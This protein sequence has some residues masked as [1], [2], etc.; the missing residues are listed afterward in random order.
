MG[1]ESNQDDMSPTGR[2][3]FTPR[4]RRQPMLLIHLDINKTIIQSDSIQMKSIEEGIREGIAE[5]FWGT[6][7][8]D[9][10]GKVVGW[11]WCKNRPSC[12]PPEITDCPPDDLYTYLSFCKKM[13]SE[14]DQQKL[15]IR[16]FRLVEDDEVKGEMIKV[17][18]LALKKLQLPAEVRFSP[19]AEAVGLKGSTIMMFPA[20][21]HLVA[22]LQRAKRKFAILFRSFGVDHENIKQEWNAFCEMRHPLYSR[23]LDGIGPMD[24]SVSRIPDRRIDAM[25]TLYRDAQGPLL[26]IDHLVE[27]QRAKDWDRWARERPTPQEDTRDG[28]D[29]ILRVLKDQQGARVPDGLDEVREWMMEHIES[30][31]TSAIKDDWAWW[32]WKN[33]DSS[34]GKLLTV[35]PDDEIK[36]VFFDDNVHH[37][38]PR[39][40]DCRYPDG[41]Q[42]APID[43]IDKLCCKVNSVEAIIDDEYFLRKLQICHGGNLLINS[44]LIDFQHQITEAEEQKAALQKDIKALQLQLKSITEENHRMK[45]LHRVDVENEVQLRDFLTQHNCPLDSFGIDGFRKVSDLYGELEQGRCCLE[46]DIDKKPVLIREMI[47]LKVLYKDLVLIESHEQYSDGRIM[48]RNFLPGVVKGLKESSFEA[49]DKFFEAGLEVN[50]S[51]CITEE[52]PPAFNP[53]AQT[54]RS[55]ATEA[56][57]IPCKVQ[58]FEA[59][60]TITDPKNF[61]SID[62]KEFQQQKDILAKIGLP[63]GKNFTTERKEM[64]GGKITHFWRW[65]KLAAW[66]ATALNPALKSD[67]TGVNVAEVVDKVFGNHPYREVYEN[68]LLQMFETFVAKKLCGG[69]SGSMVIRVQPFEKDGRPGE[70]CIVKLDRAD[71]IK[72]EH[73]NSIQ[74]FEALP[75]RAARI[76]GDAAYA[77]SEKDGTWFGAMR[78]EL[79]GA[80]WNVPELA[81]GSPNLLS[82]FKDLLLYESELMMLGALQNERNDARPFGSVNTVLAETFGPGGMV[83]S[84]RKGGKKGV[85]RSDQ[86]LPWGWYT[87]KGKDTD[88]NP[89]GKM[90]DTCTG[91]VMRQMYERHFHSEMPNLKELVVDQIKPRLERLAKK[92]MP[93]L[94]PLIGLAHG[95]LN[96]ANIMIDALDAVWLIDFATSVDLPLLTDL[97]KFEMACLFEYAILPITAEN[98]VDLSGPD[99]AHWERMGIGEWLGV[100]Q[101]VATSFLKL[102]LQ[103]VKRE[104]LASMEASQ[105]ESLVDEAIQQLPTH[106]Q[107]QARRAILSRLTASQPTRS[108]QAKTDCAFR[109]C[110]SIS[111]SMLSGDGLL[112]TLR[113]EAPRI[114]GAGTD[115]FTG[116]GSLRF[117]VDIAKSIRRFMLREIQMCFRDFKI[118]M[119]D[120]EPGELQVCDALSLQM[121][122]PFLRESYRIVGYRDIPP[123]KKLW[124]IYHCKVVAENVKR[125][126]EMLDSMD[127]LSPGSFEQLK[128]EDLTQ[129]SFNLNRIYKNLKDEITNVNF[130][131]SESVEVGTFTSEARKKEPFTEADS[132]WIHAHGELFGNEARHCR[133]VQCVHAE[134]DVYSNRPG[135][136]APIFQVVVKGQKAKLHFGED[137]PPQKWPLRL[138]KRKSRKESMLEESDTGRM[139]DPWEDLDRELTGDVSPGATPIDPPE[140]R[141]ASR[142]IFLPHSFLVNELRKARHLKSAGGQSK[143]FRREDE[144]TEDAA[145]EHAMTG[146]GKKFDGSFSIQNWF[147]QPSRL[148]THNTVASTMDPGNSR[149]AGDRPERQ[150][151][152]TMTSSGRGDSMLSV[153]DIFPKFI[154]LQAVAVDPEGQDPMQL[155][156]CLGMP[157]CCYPMGARI[158]LEV[159][160]RSEHSEQEFVITCS[161]GTGNYM[162]HKVNEDEVDDPWHG[163]LS[164]PNYSQF[165]DQVNDYDLKCN[166]H[167]YLAPCKIKAGDKVLLLEQNQWV[168]ANINESQREVGEYRI[169]LT[170]EREQIKDSETY[171]HRTPEE[172]DADTSQYGLSRQEDDGR[173]SRYL[174]PMICCQ[175]L[176]SATNFEEELSKMKAFYRARHSSIIDALSG[177]RL[178][179]RTCTIPQLH[180]MPF[181]QAL[182]QP[183]LETQRSAPSV[184]AL[185]LPSSTARRHGPTMK[186]GSSRDLG[187]RPAQKHHDE[188]GSSEQKTSW[189]L[190]VNALERYNKATPSCSPNAFWVI[191]APGSGK[192]CLMCRVIMDSVSRFDN[193]VPLRLPI[194]DLVKRTDQMPERD[195]SSVQT[196]FDK[197]MRILFGEDT[198]R[199]KMMKMAIAMRR[200]LLLFEGLDAAGSV[201]EAVK[202]LIQG[203]VKDGHFVL[204]TS[205]PLPPN[206]M[207]LE[208]IAEHLV[209]MEMQFLTDEQKRAIAN[210]RLGPQGLQSFNAFIKKIRGERGE[211]AN[212]PEDR[213]EDIF[214]NPMMLSMLLCYLSPKENEMPERKRSSTSE[215]NSKVDLMAVYRVSVSVMLKRMLLQQQAD[216]H[217]KE[218]LLIECSR[219]LERAAMNMQAKKTTEIDC[220]DFEKELTTD[221]KPCWT[222][223]RQA[224]EVGRAMLLRM[225]RE[226]TRTYIRFM[227]KGFQDY[228]SACAISNSNDMDHLPNYRA[229]LTDTWWAQM[230]DMLAQAWPK[231]YVQLMERKIG[232]FKDPDGSYLHL[233]AKEGHL[234]IFRLVRLFSD[235]NQVQIRAARANDLMTPLHVAAQHGHRL[236]CETIMDQKAPVDTEDCEERLPLHL[237]LQHGHFQLARI[238]LDR[239]EQVQTSYGAHESGQRKKNL[240]E[241]LANR[242]LTKEGLQEDDFKAEVY[243]IFLEMRY[244]RKEEQNEINRQMAALL[245]VYWVISEQYEL[246]TREQPE[247]DKLRPESWQ[248]MLEWVNEVGLTSKRVAAVL[249]Y[250][251]IVAIGKISAFQKEFAA[252]ATEPIGALAS[253]VQRHPVLVPSFQRLDE[254][255]QNLI[256][257]CLKAQAHFNFGQFLQAESLPMSLAKCKELLI[258]PQETLLHDVFS[259]FLFTVFMSLCAILGVKS[260]NGSLFMTEDMYNHNFKVGLEALKNLKEKEATTVY[261]GF[262]QKRAELA[263]VE[264]EKCSCQDQR[265]AI[266]R[267]ICLTR[268]FEKEKGKRVQDEFMSLEPDVRQELTEFLNADGLTER[269]FL[270]FHSPTFMFNAFD[271]EALSPAKAMRLL[272]KMYQLANEAFPITSDG[273][274][275][276]TVM[277][278]EVANYAKKCTDPEVFDSTNLEIKRFHGTDRTAKIVL[279]PWQIETNPELLD[280]E[281]EALFTDVSMQGCSEQTFQSRLKICFPEFKYMDDENSDEIVAEIKKRSICTMLCI[282]WLYAD[283]HME[284]TRGQ[285]VSQGLTEDSWSFLRSWL[286]PMLDDIEVLSVVCAAVMVRAI[287]SIPKFRQQQAKGLSEPRDVVAHVL[288]HCPKVLPSYQRLNPDERQQLAESLG[289][290]FELHLFL[291]AESCPAGLKFLLPLVQSET[292]EVASRRNC[293]FDPVAVLMWSSFLELAGSMGAQSQEGSL[294]MTEERFQKIRI[295]AESIQQMAESSVSEVDVYDQILEKRAKAVG[296]QLDSSLPS[297]ALKRLSCLAAS[298]DNTDAEN[299][300]QALDALSDEDRGRMVKYLTNGGS[301]APED[302]EPGGARPCFAMLQATAFLEKARDNKE[303]GLAQATRTLLRVYDEAQREFQHVDV[304]M[305]KVRLEKLA[306]FAA[307]FVGSAQFED[308]PFELKRFSSLEVEVMPKVWIPV[309]NQAVLDDL[310][311]SACKL[312][313]ELREHKLSE[314]R[315]RERL[316]HVYPELGYFVAGATPAG[317][318]GQAGPAGPAP[319]T[320]RDQSFCALCCVFWLLMNQRDNF[321]RGQLQDEELSRQSWAWI[322]DWL[323][324]SVKLNTWE[325]IDAALS[326]MAVHALGKYKAFREDFASVQKYTQEMHDLALAQILEE[327][328]EVVPSVNRLDKKYKSLIIDCLSVDF[329]FSQF[330]LGENT[331]AN[332]VMVK[333]RLKPHG[334]EG[335]AFF[336]F[337]IFA[338]MCGKK[339]QESQI[340]SLFMTESMFKRCTPGLKA[341]QSLWTS[342]GA[343]CWADFMLL[344]GSKAMSRFASPEHEALS[345]LLCLFGAFDKEEGS[346]LCNA[347]DELDSA[348]RG[349]LTRWLNSAGDYGVVIPNASGMLQNAKKNPSVGLVNALRIMVKVREECRRHEEG[350]S[351]LANLRRV[352]VQFADLASWAKDYHGDH[353]AEVCLR[354]SVDLQGDT[355]VITLE[356]EPSSLSL[357]PSCAANTGSRCREMSEASRRSSSPASPAP[358]GPASFSAASPSGHRRSPVVHDSTTQTPQRSEGSGANLLGPAPGPRSLRSSFCLGRY[359]LMSLSFLWAL[360]ALC[361]GEA[362]LTL[363]W[364]S[365]LMS[366]LILALMVLALYV[367]C[368]N[369]EIPVETASEVNRLGAGEPFLAQWGVVHTSSREPQY[370]RLQTCDDEVP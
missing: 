296:L 357:A 106:K 201:T 270:L 146:E 301:Q 77:N 347:F 61:Q 361:M 366:L 134:C 348:E 121:W 101:D 248:H 8:K 310:N 203:F 29:Y 110:E 284:F 212:G 89:Y 75:D 112:E 234:P 145:T 93:G 1:E 109:Y 328:P 297:K 324:K 130:R 309:I 79:A 232:E 308:V 144:A 100:Q 167:I 23:F 291:D 230:L 220:D 82:T 97:C 179:V 161:K 114:E 162:L 2:S 199:Y 171:P 115:K 12:S 35:F 200:A 211:E 363:S 180:V 303:I 127:D 6:L 370:S 267:L 271:N 44:S 358:P 355:K 62:Q 307:D 118:G 64:S 213:S 362:E 235:S 139:S 330:L 224:V 9:E 49:I 365:L 47:F 283:R 331:V 73:V 207:N 16:T 329:E 19:E 69:F 81:T 356:V 346:V 13:H 113:A 208:G 159:G 285:A 237:A 195:Q 177:T 250:C 253:I 142:L 173:V 117:F 312:C 273:A 125:T 135:L 334:P 66:E 278:E 22:A 105:L 55:L 150:R 132:R 350:G 27:A 204:M 292:P 18:D 189:N 72:E 367:Q 217:I 193:L 160:Q 288:K 221:L 351:G 172:E 95:D 78:L 215:D 336:L 83:S 154:S 52:A 197:Y 124:S 354:S 126:L 87:L 226:G 178:D 158:C 196:W 262:L 25:H 222:I 293:D 67:Q 254:E 10:N 352:V 36:Q 3:D 277:V 31:G 342:D 88:F 143:T 5:L 68:L 223:I 210:Q 70:P 298:R 192:N 245:S 209:V 343:D 229:L 111:K 7:R 84:L 332:L 90:R 94:C 275:V 46:L 258:C 327:R 337:R 98:L 166:N 141:L 264:F 319:S 136:F 99:E 233:A 182:P 122:L 239:L 120:R 14:K 63:T 306:N 40:I 138:K 54:Q 314:S 240:V 281:V 59:T 272:L 340:G 38:D 349:G 311:Q 225:H 299:V 187:K 168:N 353:P 190:I 58:Q 53:E 256:V 364:R 286:Q 48:S 43:S 287:C 169:N 218:D 175:A 294:Y 184:G 369:L 345:R 325:T 320:L 323:Q 305:V 108:A 123:Q 338:Q 152:S 276:I 56:Y 133:I 198:P 165:K 318:A 170:L 188:M 251:A 151:R 205:R 335:H 322:Q 236:V 164:L 71:A 246:F 174:N 153:P 183:P 269:G 333:E 214:G 241:A 92:N 85:T 266:V 137:K 300:R 282:Y 149:G 74:V 39:I 51:K 202:L 147:P 344:R 326:F 279:S 341:L 259:F 313:T 228:F 42:V 24:G 26:V 315:F 37:S 148:Q 4:P 244:F 274:G 304:A 41:S 181:G 260:L 163:S 255:E 247:K 156:I 33:E 140:V 261:D 252:E 317:P 50:L 368:N 176:L 231:K 242:M 227:I 91:Q 57:P 15:S 128:M 238:L 359:T 194:M 21:F 76:I 290:D 30:E 104:K 339:G 263:Q 243:K 191:G 316:C 280:K 360:V 249:V 321:I 45:I 65:D 28:R 265:K 107:P 157:V 185:A 257:Y 32:A 155:E 219:V 20:V 216:R 119:E 302:A 17:L 116:C 11:D 103:K 131:R 34:A 102:L 96:A 295:A 186:F 80:C 129:G 60:F 86:Q 268:I 289:H 206:M